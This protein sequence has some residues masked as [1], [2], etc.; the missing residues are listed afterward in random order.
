MGFLCFIY[1]ICGIR[2]NMVMEF[3]FL[4]LT[5]GL[6]LLA[7]S[8]CQAANMKTGLASSLLVASCPYF[9]VYFGKSG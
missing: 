3:I 4:T 1:L 2:T 5:V 9:Q 6:F 8:Y 7:G